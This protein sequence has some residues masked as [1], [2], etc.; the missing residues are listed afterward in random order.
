[1][2]RMAGLVISGAKLGMN[3]YFA[4]DAKVRSENKQMREAERRELRAKQA[5][6]RANLNGEARDV[7]AFAREERRIKEQDLKADYK[8]ETTAIRKDFQE[9]NK[10]ASKMLREELE[11]LR[12][13]GKTEEMTVVVE[14]HKAKSAELRIEQEQAL[15]E[16]KEML[17]KALA[18]LREENKATIS[19]A[20]AGI[21]ER[22]QEAKPG[23]IEAGPAPEWVPDEKA[24]TCF[25]CSNKFDLLHRRH[26]CRACGNVFCTGCC[27]QKRPLPMFNLGVERV[28]TD[29]L[30]KLK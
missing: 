7:I 29:C 22:R 23:K 24:P 3:A 17:D 25:R 13:E 26:H 6:D 11:R 4:H 21:K 9:S 19:E 2:V 12:K 18:E 16:Q 30:R 14:E 27:S 10:E 20:K 28:C 1:L 15:A 5:A 8:T